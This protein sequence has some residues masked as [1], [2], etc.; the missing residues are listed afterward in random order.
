MQTLETTYTG[1]AASAVTTTEKLQAIV[2]RLEYLNTQAADLRAQV[3][4]LDAVG[5]IEM[6]ARRIDQAVADAWY[7][8]TSRQRGEW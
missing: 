7:I 6:H 5:L 2:D 8:A 3:A 4:E 1:R